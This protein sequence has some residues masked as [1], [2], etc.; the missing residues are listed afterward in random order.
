L[1]LFRDASHSVAMIRHAMNVVISATDHLNNGQ[2]PA[3]I[4]DQ[5]LFALAK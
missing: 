3:L 1:P 4:V 5:P 2:I